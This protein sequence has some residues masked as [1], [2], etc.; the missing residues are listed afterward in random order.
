MHHDDP[1]RDTIGEEMYPMNEKLSGVMNIDELGEYLKLP[2]PTVYKLAQRGT[3]PGRKAG[4]QWRFH[5]EAIDKWLSESPAV[6]RSKNG[7]E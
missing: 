4:R 7:G 2:K 1:V 6:G 5:K 3:I